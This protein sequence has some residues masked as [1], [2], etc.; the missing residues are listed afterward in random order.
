MSGTAQIA[1]SHC[2]VD[3]TSAA[4]RNGTLMM[5]ISCVYRRAG[6]P[7]HSSPRTLAEL[8]VGGVWA[9]RVSQ[10]LRSTPADRRHLQRL[11]PSSSSGRM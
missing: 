9:C 6:C 10:G 11:P 8:D 1:S 7:R 2:A 3:D 4:P 5:G